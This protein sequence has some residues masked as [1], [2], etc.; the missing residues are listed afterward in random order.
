VRILYVNPVGS[1]ELDRHYEE[2]LA[3]CAGA[4]V[5]VAATHLDLPEVPESPFLPQEP[6]YH[7][8][9]FKTLMRAQHDGFDGVAIGCS[10]DPGLIDARRFLEIPVAAPLDSALHLAAQLHQRLAILV[11]DGFE[12]HVLYRD[13]ARYYGLSHLISEILT[14]PMAYPDPERLEQLMRDDQS[15]AMR[16]VMDRHRSV[17]LDDALELARGAVARGAG[18]VYAGCTFWAGE[19]LDPFRR[20]LGVPVI[21]PAKGAVAMAAAAARSSVAARTLEGAL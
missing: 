20:A 5:E 1:G 13:L 8:A 9:L 2:L 15:E 7:A 18:V 17:L 4:D 12:A 14:V 19:M 3:G 16:L 11:A 6:Y 21:D 10:G